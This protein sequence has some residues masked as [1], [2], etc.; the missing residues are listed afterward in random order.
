M[1]N[2]CYAWSLFSHCLQDVCIRSFTL[3][4]LCIVPSKT[5]CSRIWANFAQRRAGE[6]ELREAPRKLIEYSIRASHCDPP[7]QPEK[8]TGE[9]AFRVNEP[10]RTPPVEP[11]PFVTRSDADPIDGTLYASNRWSMDP[12]STSGP[13]AARNRIFH[14]RFKEWLFLFACKLDCR[15]DAHCAWTRFHWKREKEKEKKKK[16]KERRL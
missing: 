6:D 11:A 16:S 9:P 13:C 2:H 4:I 14:W 1:Q 8:G 10:L 3:Y 5:N 7:G 15:P 12:Y